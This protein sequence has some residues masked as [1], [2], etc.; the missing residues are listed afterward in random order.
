M[1]GLFCTVTERD[2]VRNRKIF[3]PPSRINYRVDFRHY[4]TDPYQIWWLAAH[5]MLRLDARLGEIWGFSPL[6]FARGTFRKSA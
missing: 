4:L 5:N 6:I 2:I 3:P 1:M